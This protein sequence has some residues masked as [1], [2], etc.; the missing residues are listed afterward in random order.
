MTVSLA[1]RKKTKPKHDL[2]ISPQARTLTLN[3]FRPNSPLDIEVRDIVFHPTRK[4]LFTCA[5]G[6]LSAFNI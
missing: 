5:D 1:V 6:M 4:M 2:H 3:V